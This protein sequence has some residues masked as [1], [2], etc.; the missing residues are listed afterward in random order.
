[1]LEAY[2]LERDAPNSL[3]RKEYFEGTIQIGAFPRGMAAG[4]WLAWI[5]A[6]KPVIL[7]LEDI[8][9]KRFRSLDTFSQTILQR[10]LQTRELQNYHAAVREKL[11]EDTYTNNS[12]IQKYLGDIA[13]WNRKASGWCFWIKFKPPIDTKVLFESR[14]GISFNPGF[15]YDS[16]DSSHIMLNPPSLTKED[17]EKGL[18]KLREEILYLFPEAFEE[19]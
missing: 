12:L 1:M 16:A 4:T 15:F 3:F 11:R 2:N 10:L 18:K 17:F 7:R 9:E 14:K 5:V 19:K 6:P 8:K 13:N